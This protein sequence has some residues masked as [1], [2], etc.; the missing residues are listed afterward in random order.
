MAVPFN[1]AELGGWSV[2]ASFAAAA[3]FC[4]GSDGANDHGAGRVLDILPAGAAALDK[5]SCG[6]GQSETYFSEL[7]GFSMRDTEFLLNASCKVA[8]VGVMPFHADEPRRIGQARLI[9]ETTQKR[10]PAFNF[11]ECNVGCDLYELAKG[12]CT[13]RRARLFRLYPVEVGLEK[14]DEE[15]LAAVEV[16]VDQGLRDPCLPGK[17]LHAEDIQSLRCNQTRSAFQNLGTTLLRGQ[18]RSGSGLTGRWHQMGF[19]VIAVVC[20]Y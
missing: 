8:G 16:G 7:Q 12:S 10:A 20:R 5:L 9:E 19:T 4:T 11:A 3:M 13:L 18:S 15:A 6:D 1:A 17:A 14:R 2:P